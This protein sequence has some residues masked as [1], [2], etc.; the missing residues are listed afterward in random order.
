MSINNFSWKTIIPQIMGYVGSILLILSM[1]AQIRAYYLSKDVRTLSYGFIFFQLAVN[2]MY[3]VYNI[4]IFSLPILIGNGSMIVLLLTM[5][6]QKYYYTHVYQPSSPEQ[7][8][9]EMV[10]MNP[11]STHMNE[12]LYSNSDQ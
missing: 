8:D 4:S 3:L 12:Y 9:I 11:S 7:H 6:G 5:L 10:D 2:V 1:L